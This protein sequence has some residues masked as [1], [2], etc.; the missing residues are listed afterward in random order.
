MSRVTGTYIWKSSGTFSC[1]TCSLTRNW[2]SSA[3][4]WSVG[5]AVGR[6]RGRRRPT[7]RRTSACRSPRAARRPGGSPRSRPGGPVVLVEL[8][9]DPGEAVLVHRLEIE[10]QDAEHVDHPG[11]LLVHDGLVVVLIVV[12]GGEHPV[13]QRDRPGLRRCE[14]GCC[15]PLLAQHVEVLA[16]S[17]R[18]RS[19]CTTGRRNRRSLRS[20][21]GRGSWLKST[22]MPHHWCATSWARKTSS[23]PVR[24]VFWKVTQERCTIPGKASPWKLGDLGGVEVVHGRGTVDVWKNRRLLLMSAPTRLLHLPLLTST[25]PASCAPPRRSSPLPAECHPRDARSP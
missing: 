11:A 20:A 7:G 9:H 22:P 4:R 16:R 1:L 12:L 10:H 5:D 19:A 24:Q 6:N 25:P 21:T 2:P 17:C 18:A 8:P 14:R 3:G 13:A 15:A 23:S